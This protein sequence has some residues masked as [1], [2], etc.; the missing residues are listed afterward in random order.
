M[1][2]GIIKGLMGD[3]VIL[4]VDGVEIQLAQKDIIK[5]NLDF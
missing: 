2:R 1:Y 3:M 5:A 4:D